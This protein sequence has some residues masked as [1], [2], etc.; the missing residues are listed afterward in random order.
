MSKSQSVSLGSAIVDAVTTI[1]KAV[2]AVTTGSAALMA[3][4]LHSAG[5]TVASFGIWWSL[6][7]ERARKEMLMEKEESEQASTGK[8]G[9]EA[10]QIEQAWS[11]DRFRFYKEHVEKKLA[12][13]IGLLF[14][15][16][17][18]WGFW[19]AAQT[20][21]PAAFRIATGVPILVLLGLG[22]ISYLVSRFVYQVSIIEDVRDLA[23]GS[24]R[25]KADAVGS[26][27]VALV[28]FCRYYDI[29]G[30]GLDRTIALIISVIVF[31]Q[32]LE[33]I[34][35]TIRAGFE[36]RRL[37][38][39]EADPH[40]VAREMI[41]A[42]LLS[43]S[44][45][46]SLLGFLSAGLSMQTGPRR[47][48]R[49]IQKHLP[50]VVVLTAILLWGQSASLIVEPSDCVIIE[51]FGRAINLE[52]PLG[53]GWH[54]KYPWPIDR[55]VVIPIRTIQQVNIGYEQLPNTNEHDGSYILWEIPHHQQEYQ[56]VTGDGSL[57]S[58][59]MVISYRIKEDPKE[60]YLTA[61]S[62][63][64]ILR[65]E[66]DR[67][68][69]ENIRTKSLFW[70]IGPDRPELAEM[71]HGQIQQVLDEKHVGLEVLQVNLLNAHPPTSLNDNENVAKAY[72]QVFDKAQERQT[73]LNQAELQ[74]VKMIDTEAARA[75]AISFEAFAQ[76]WEIVNKARGRTEGF[77][78]M[79]RL[80]ADKPEY[81][82]LVRSELFLKYLQEA[83]GEQTG[84]II[85]DPR[86]AESNVEIRLQYPRRPI[87]YLEG[88]SL[89]SPPG[90]VD[91]QTENK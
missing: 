40:A 39:T 25:A 71:I 5:D 30:D 83:L 6:R 67:L 23:T 64:D 56:L 85:L 73:F 2:F 88:S 53:P 17:S 45:W 87:P 41:L 8:W 76:G 3:E 31:L 60:F 51:R 58:L 13:I 46:I 32:G 90:P 75:A 84:K 10:E 55:K 57:V 4:T 24:A 37:A 22:L 27:L 21:Q 26:V 81:L 1:I 47:P 54:V 66:A 18:A 91:T 12:I 70:V 7:F 50:L 29:A 68:L 44:G 63:R 42:R 89:L 77:A 65:T 62:P 15:A 82:P 74:T 61:R 19:R 79:L 9:L 34:I 11:A 20:P 38:D 69:G 59:G 16:F 43:G 48:L 49:F 35:S 33:I 14:I 52:D 28:F 78:S 80:V 86:A 36:D 72:L